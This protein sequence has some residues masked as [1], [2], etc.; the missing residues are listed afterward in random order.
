MAITTTSGSLRANGLKL[1][2]AISILD[3]E[4]TGT[5]V[6]IDRIVEIGILKV[7]PDG[8]KRRFSQRVNPEM[9]NPERGYGGSRHNRRGRCRRAHIQED[10]TRG[11]EIPSRQRSGRIQSE[12]FRPTHVAGGIRQ[13]RSAVF[14]RWSSRDRREGHLPS[15]SNPEP[16]PTHCGFIATPSIR[17][18]ILRWRMPKR[19]GACYALR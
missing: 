10:R 9:Q 16:S 2:R 3:L 18:P 14:L 6:E 12:E 15:S 5:F 17:M 7:L 11:G 13:S 19:R 1:H 8:T 4:T